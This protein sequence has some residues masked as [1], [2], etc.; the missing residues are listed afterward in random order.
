M[1]DVKRGIHFE[2]EYIFRPYVHGL[3]QSRFVIPRN[4]QLNISSL[5][6]NQSKA[7]QD[8]A[9]S[10]DSYEQPSTSEPFYSPQLTSSPLMSTST[11]QGG[12]I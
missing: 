10:D 7:D 8:F 3:M 12:F 6:G 5:N 11:C 9:D 2:T 1:G 4:K